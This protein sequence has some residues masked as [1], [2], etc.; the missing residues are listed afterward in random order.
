MLL[1]GPKIASPRASGTYTVGVPMWMWAGPSPT[2]FGPNTASATLA[3]GTASATANVSSSRWSTGDEKTVTCQGAGTKC[4]ASYGMSKSPDCGHFYRT[5]A[6]G[7]GGRPLQGRGDRNV[8]CGLA[9]ESSTK[10]RTTAVPAPA[11]P[12]GDIMRPDLDIIDPEPPRRG[13]RSFMVIDAVMVLADAIGFAVLLNASGER[14]DVLALARDVPAGSKIADRQPAP[15][16]AIQPPPAQGVL[17][18]RADQHH[19]R[20]T[21]PGLLPQEARRG[22]QARPGR[23]RPGSPTGECVVGP[24][25]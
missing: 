20:R 7:P 11:P 3:G 23:H 22:L 16:Q 24:V 14:S 21:E 8:G 13:N 6:Q 25:A 15:A 17:P 18:V 12:H 1:T 5:S 4:K 9:G 19:P 2:T 10:T